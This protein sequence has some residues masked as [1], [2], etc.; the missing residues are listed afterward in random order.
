MYIASQILA[1]ASTV[2]LL[3]YSVMKVKRETILICNIAINLLLSCHYAL[4]KSYTGALCT[5]VITVMV[6]AFYYKNRVKMRY[7][8]L[9]FIGFISLLLLCGA[10]TWE[11]GWSAIAVIGN[12][13]LAIALWNDN[14]NVIKGLFILVGILWIILNAH[15]KSTAAVIGQVLSVLSNVVYFCRNRR[16]LNGFLSKAT[17]DYPSHPDDGTC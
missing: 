1:A 4:L 6:F 16:S 8:R 9:M 13:L 11:D 5:G 15:L 12:V 3:V 7:R 14:E 2:I 10:L 17:F